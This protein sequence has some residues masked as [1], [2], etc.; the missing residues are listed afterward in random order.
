MSA[1]HCYKISPIGPLASYRGARAP[2]N[3]G[4]NP[5]K[6]PKHDFKIHCIEFVP[7]L[8]IYEQKF[9][10][11]DPEVNQHQIKLQGPILGS[12]CGFVKV[13]EG[14]LSPNLTPQ[15]PIKCF[16]FIGRAREFTMQKR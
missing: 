10:D 1:L 2:K 16:K 12:I 6:I 11:S 7:C 8:E 3:M 4:Q 15:C 13:Q 5:W 14:T 9:I